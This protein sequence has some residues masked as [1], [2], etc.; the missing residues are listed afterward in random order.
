MKNKYPSRGG[1]ENEL[2]LAGQLNPERE[3]YEGEYKDSLIMSVLPEDLI[4]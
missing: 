3:L 2:Q 1:A 4:R